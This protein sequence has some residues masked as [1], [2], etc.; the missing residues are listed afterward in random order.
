[1]SMR[2][3]MAAIHIMWRKSIYL[4][5]EWRPTLGHITM[6]VIIFYQTLFLTHF[7]IM[8]RLSSLLLC[9]SGHM[10]LLLLCLLIEAPLVFC[11]VHVLL[12]FDSKLF[13]FLFL[14]SASLFA[15]AAPTSNVVAAA[16]PAIPDDHGECE[17]RCYDENRF[18]HRPPYECEHELQECLRHC[19]H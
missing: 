5:I 8:V 9:G 12:H 3:E 10:L 14:S 4:V 17:R 2:L 13:V 18:C 1:M 15:Q 11:G 16:A 6:T 19:H 7:N